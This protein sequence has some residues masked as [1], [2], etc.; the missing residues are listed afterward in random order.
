M[1]GKHQDNNLQTLL[2]APQLEARLRS[3]S[4]KA[5]ISIQE[6]GSNILFLAIGFLEWF[7]DRSSEIKRSAP[8]FTIPIVIERSKKPS[9]GVFQ[10]SNHSK[11]KMGY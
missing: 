6:S 1:L 10:Y 3:I 8:L 7:E 4:G 11:K 5:K 9:K 2:Y